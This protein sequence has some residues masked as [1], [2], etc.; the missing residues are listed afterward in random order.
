YLE[1]VPGAAASE[2]AGSGRQR[3]LLG[4]NAA[5]G[6]VDVVVASELLEAAR[7][8]EA[9]FVTPDRTLLI[10]STARV[11]TIEEKS[12]L[13]DGRLA[14]ER[15][16][17]LARRFARGAI[18]ADFA[19][20]AAA[21]RAPLNAVLLGAL[22][23]VGRLPIPADAFR[24][25]VREEGRAV[26]PNLRG[27]EAGLASAGTSVEASPGPSADV[28][29]TARLARF[30]AAARA[31]LAVAIERL[32]DYQDAS[33]A[34]RYLVRVG[35]FLGRP[36][37]DGAFLRELARHLAVRMSVEDVIRVAQ[38][39]VRAARLAALV[40]QAGVAGG[41]IVDVTE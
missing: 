18:L 16:L 8:I 10:A 3:L 38:L 31:L 1:I 9:G 15:L 25:A 37:A 32:T 2:A 17:A 20:Q 28:P 27:F 7:A 30:P 33:Y 6:E 5:P 13:R 11:F 22:A 12:A 29:A 24:A 19:A 23:A 34:E 39:K 26:E 14:G 35:R 40:R 41:D 21:V 4:L 36:H